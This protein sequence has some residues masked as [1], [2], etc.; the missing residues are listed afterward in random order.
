MQMQPGQSCLSIFAILMAICLKS[1]IIFE[2]VALQDLWSD[3]YLILDEI[4]LKK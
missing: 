4:R 3:D 2:V 1:R